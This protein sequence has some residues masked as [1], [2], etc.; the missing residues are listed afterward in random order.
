MFNGLAENHR[1]GPF[2]ILVAVRNAQDLTKLL[3]TAY[4]IAH[5]RGGE[6]RVL[7]VNRQGTKPPWFQV[8]D[9]Y[10]SVPIETFTLAGRNI[11]S[12]ILQEVHRFEADL[13]I[14]GWRGPLAQGRYLLGRTLDPVVQGASC[15]VA[16]QRGEIPPHP[17]R[18]LIP[19]AGGP[20]APRALHVARELAPDAE[21][22]ALYVA[23]R[24]L[25]P[26]QVMIGQARLDTMAHN[27][28][29][30]D[31]NAV[32]TKVIQAGSPLEGI[33][34]ESENGYDL[35]LL[36]AGN[37][38]VVGRFL[39]GDVPQAVLSEAA[40]PVMVV[41]RRLTHLG[42]FWRRLWQRVFGL[43][44]PLTVEEQADVQ[45]TM[46]RGS[47]PSPDFFVTLTLAAALAAMGLLMDNSG[48]VIG[49]MIV[50]PLM[51]AILGMGLA[52]VLGD[53]R[54]FW[55]ATATTIRGSLLALAMGFIV[56]LIVPTRELTNEILAFS[57]P[58]L[59]DLAVALT[60]G[61]AAA[62]AIS[63][64]E[65]SAALA[66]VAVAASLTPPLVN[67]GLGLAMREW[68]IAWR[69][70]LLFLANIVSI[71]ATSGLVF[72]W[73]GF[74]PQ[75]GQ[76]NRR[77]MLRRGFWMFGL[78]LVLVTIP[79]VTLT[80]QSVQTLRLKR[81]VETALQ[82]EIAVLDDTE[83]VEWQHRIDND[84]VLRLDVT[85]RAATTVTYF[86]ARMLQ[87]RITARLGQ[88][89]A[90]SLSMV[91]TTR[92]EA[93]IPPTSTPTPPPTSTGMPSATPTS[94]S[95]PRPTATR[96]PSPTPTST[97]IPTLTPLPTLTPFPTHTATPTPWLVVIEE[98]GTAG[99]RVRYSPD[100]TVMGRLTEGET[101][102]ILEGPVVIEGEAWYRITTPESRLEGWVVG[103]YLAP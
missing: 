83:V 8:P 21:I 61:V 99:L 80:R 90:L 20:N 78:L 52:I 98:V 27:L 62:Y 6:I 101:V 55:R 74:R 47:Q 87:E 63:R 67:T 85:L 65:V 56:G 51:I 12:V 97:P 23:D 72:I 66:G 96:T 58:A 57:Q 69:A 86:D 64:K 102:E 93:Y 25:G 13:L 81:S 45:R 71:V 5:Q 89:V 19:A 14:M 39:F 46:R 53:L 95:T 92:L 35:L 50:A 42:S 60:A 18:I 79:L 77:L 3:R 91:P 94:T 100:G 2:R 88:P 26:T 43:V 76:P 7:T 38:N 32:K 17:K 29:V 59:L 49:A 10:D 82:Q 48:I 37:E 75:P 30:T 68:H 24:S 36:G 15:D 4:P 70:G 1:S 40:I 31:R 16:V 28:P 54:F 103:Q 9:E 44:P 84:D 33:L 22:T 41:R 11:A 34:N 73:M